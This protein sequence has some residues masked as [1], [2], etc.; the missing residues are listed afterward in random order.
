MQAAVDTLAAVTRLETAIGV[1]R[2]AAIGRLTRRAEAAQNLA[3]AAAPL[4]PFVPAG[5]PALAT[6]LDEAR[7]KVDVRMGPFAPVSPPA[8]QAQPAPA[9][10]Q[11]IPLTPDGIA[12]AE[13]LRDEVSG[14]W[15][16]IT[17]VITAATGGLADLRQRVEIARTLRN[18]AQ[19]LLHHTGSDEADLTTELDAIGPRLE[20]LN[21]RWWEAGV[22]TLPEVARG[23]TRAAP[24]P[25]GPTDAAHVDDTVAQTVAALTNGAL[26]RAA[27]A[28]ERAAA[29]IVAAAITR[30]RQTAEGIRDSAERLL[31]LLPDGEEK[32]ELNGRLEYADLQRPPILEVRHEDATPQQIAREL[33]VTAPFIQLEESTSFI[34]RALNDRLRQRS[35]DLEAA[36]QAGPEL[37]TGRAA[38]EAR[39]ARRAL[40]DLVRRADRLLGPPRPSTG[41]GI[42]HG[43]RAGTQLTPQQTQQ[44]IQLAT[45][46]RAALA[47]A[48]AA[49]VAIVTRS[50][51][52]LRQR[53]SNTRAFAALVRVQLA[54]SGPL[55]S[56]VEELNRVA[57][58]PIPAK[59][60]A[61]LTRT[62]EL[63]RAGAQVE[64]AS[65]E[66]TRRFSVAPERMNTAIDQAEAARELLR[67]TG[68][69]QGQ[70]RSELDGALQGIRAAARGLPRQPVAREPAQELA[71]IRATSHWLGVLERS[72]ADVLA[73]VAVERGRLRREVQ[74]PEAAAAAAR[75]L[76]PHTGEQQTG[77]TDSLGRATADLRAARRP[78]WWPVLETNLTT[79]A[80]IRAAAAALDRQGMQDFQDAATA[81][82]RA[83]ADV[84]AAANQE[85]QGRQTDLAGRVTT[86]RGLLRHA[87]DRE[88]ALAAE[89]D[90]VA[91]REPVP[92]S[93]PATLAGVEA[94]SRDIDRMAAAEASVTQIADQA[95]VAAR[96]D[97]RVADARALASAARALLEHTGEPQRTRLTSALAA[98]EAEL[99]EPPPAMGRERLATS[100]Q[101]LD[102]AA[103]LQTA[104]RDVLV[105]STAGLDGAWRG[106]RAALD[107]A[108]DV[109][110][111]MPFTGAAQDDLTRRLEEAHGRSHELQPGRW[112]R[113][114][115]ESRPGRWQ[116]PEPARCHGGKPQGGAKGGGRAGSRPAPVHRRGTHGH[117][118]GRS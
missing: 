55:N 85:L 16:T 14:L 6:P 38:D 7:R 49:M 11:P 12:I 77:L 27:A 97:Q 81:A 5:H 34:A 41:P 79:A 24:D 59:L 103:T 20:G 22:W 2:T 67:H 91:A 19:D 71:A 78:A 87:G 113:V 92:S 61:R 70:F 107:W 51:E 93:W 17:G 116:T 47:R 99:P 110:R 40:A 8:T 43:T 80:D 48:E 118:V 46:T 64:A 36:I 23:E 3:K 33:H 108:S 18:A 82:D 52:P 39:A 112:G 117:R 69:R 65:R 15:N 29:R 57:A 104:A 54:D 101:A 13:R 53:I 102:R 86:A 42:G 115:D 88:A 89:L 45:E 106:V 73:A 95:N 100:Q 66:V 58:L 84:L 96:M 9:Q 63:V 76:L 26:D 31:A 10:P 50:W 25:S 62:G 68:D 21:P 1:G 28:T 4:L 94:A 35:R 109:R 98:A 83:V 105:E 114:R 111:L 90:N 72:T 30:W 75:H 74:A 60:T 44:A 32:A 56:A 37:G